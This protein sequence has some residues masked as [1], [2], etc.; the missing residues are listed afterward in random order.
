M[1]DWV[2]I[3]SAIS[4]YYY[5]LLTSRQIKYRASSWKHSTPSSFF[6]TFLQVARAREKG[7][8]NIKYLYETSYIRETRH[9]L[10]YPSQWRWLV[11]DQPG[12]WPP[13]LQWCPTVVSVAD[14]K[15]QLFAGMVFHRIRDAATCSTNFPSASFTIARGLFK[16]P[17][18][19]K[20]LFLVDQKQMQMFLWNSNLH[21]INWFADWCYNF[22][23]FLFSLL[24]LYYFIILLYLENVRSSQKAEILYKTHILKLY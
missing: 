18:T 11:K 20:E 16:T 12:S 15:P 1:T 3:K 21:E 22:V 4:N 5:I 2:E 19:T 8:K 10:L 14:Q 6:A 7:D 13:V 9:A 24:F 17:I 23:E